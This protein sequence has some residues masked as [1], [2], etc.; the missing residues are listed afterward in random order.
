M[1]YNKEANLVI[2]INLHNDYFIIAMTKWDNECR[3]YYT[4]LYI[5]HKTI[6]ILDKLE[7]FENIECTTTSTK[8]IN[9]EVAN[10]VINKFK[11]GDFDYYIDRF[12][13][14]MKC[15]DKGNEFFENERI[16]NNV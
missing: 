4:T 15:F 8:E 13:Y 16:K 3:K 6:D 12:E 7:S 9:S 10:F 5:K 1:K 2:S 14:Q 11:S